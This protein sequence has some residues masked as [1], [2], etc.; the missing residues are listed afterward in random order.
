MPGACI[1]GIG[2]ACIGGA[3]GGP[4]PG[5]P[6]PAAGG[7]MPPPGAPGTVGVPN[8]RVYS[9]GTPAG[10]GAGGAA[11]LSCRDMENAPVALDGC[12]GAVGANGAWAVGCP[13]VGAFA[14]Y[15]VNSLELRAG[16]GEGG[17]NAPTGPLGVGGPA[18][19]GFG[20]SG[21][22]APNSSWPDCG[23]D[24]NRLVNSPA[25]CFGAA[26]GAGIV[27]GPGGGAVAAW[28]KAVNGEGALDPGEGGE[29]G[30]GCGT[31]G[32]HSAAGASGVANGDFPNSI[33][34]SPT[35]ACAGLA[36]G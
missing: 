31:G 9:P 23:G 17:G 16:G 12:C 27:A 11:G 2:G 22:G 33:V 36:S 24:E 1:P 3:A 35:P 8:M 29:G 6:A 21:R 30:P 13:A 10:G 18:T 28:N 5:N 34:N 32:P 25:V 4:N 7:G 14:K 26:G 15:F 19:G 20:C